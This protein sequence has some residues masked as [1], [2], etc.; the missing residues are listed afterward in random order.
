MAIADCNA[1]WEENE[2]KIIESEENEV[3]VVK[4]FSKRE[5][6]LQRGQDALRFEL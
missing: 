1:E 6:R 2:C 3:V 4:E 5:L